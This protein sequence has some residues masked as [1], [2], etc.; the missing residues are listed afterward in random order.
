[1]KRAKARGLGTEKSGPCSGCTSARV[2]GWWGMQK[3]PG[4]VG[5]P[6]STVPGDP[7]QVQSP[8]WT[9]GPPV[10]SLESGRVLPRAQSL[11]F[12]ERGLGR[13][14]LRTLAGSLGRR[15]RRSLN[16]P[17]PPRIQIYTGPERRRGREGEEMMSERWK[18]H[19]VQ[20]VER[21]LSMSVLTVESK[22]PP[23]F[24]FS[25]WSR[26]QGLHFCQAPMGCCCW[27]VARPWSRPSLLVRPHLA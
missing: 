14:S 19:L 3:T 27:S 12:T 24:G 7:G 4:P 13:S 5:V 8:P 20:S 15:A 11:P 6:A 22:C 2:R 23:R 25:D 9:T 18:V 21:M 26:A 17:A 16:I 10:S 1:M